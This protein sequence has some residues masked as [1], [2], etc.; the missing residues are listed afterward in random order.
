MED[1]EEVIYSLSNG[2]IANDLEWVWK[3]LLL[4]KTFV[5]PI[6]DKV[7]FNYDMFPGKLQITHGFLFKHHCQK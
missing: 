6:T 3:S 1:K 4:F 5:I 7:R 2:M